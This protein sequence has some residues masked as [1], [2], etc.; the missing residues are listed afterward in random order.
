MY[1]C[2]IKSNLNSNKKNVDLFFLKEPIEYTREGFKFILYQLFLFKIYCSCTEDN[3]DNS[4]KSE[5]LKDLRKQMHYTNKL[6]LLLSIL[7]YKY[8]YYKI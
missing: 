3:T 8:R 2:F 5:S 1:I 6:T 7:V 4:P